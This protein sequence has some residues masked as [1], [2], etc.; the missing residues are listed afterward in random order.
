M[1]VSVVIGSLAGGMDVAAMA[2]EYGVT[3]EDIQAALKFANE[4]I[5]QASFNNPHQVA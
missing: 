3:A 5:A 4:L 2:A 1:P